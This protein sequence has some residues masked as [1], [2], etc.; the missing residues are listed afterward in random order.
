M[1]PIMI[2]QRA[3]RHPPGVDAV[4]FM[5]GVSIVGLI[6]LAFFAVLVPASAAAI[7]PAQPVPGVVL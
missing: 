4:S 1:L 5:T 7:D 6:G 3:Q 2:R